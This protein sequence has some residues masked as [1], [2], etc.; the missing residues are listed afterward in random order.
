MVY[1]HATGKWLGNE[2]ESDLAG[3]DMSDDDMSSSTTGFV[4]SVR[5]S[6]RLSE[7]FNLDLALIQEFRDRENQHH[8]LDDW[9][10]NTSG[11]SESLVMKRKDLKKALTQRIVG[12]CEFAAVAR[13]RLLNN[14]R[15]YESDYDTDPFQSA[16]EHPALH[17]DG[18]ESDFEADFVDVPQ[19][20][21]HMRTAPSL[22]PRGLAPLPSPRAP[23]R[24]PGYSG[25]TIAHRRYEHQR[26][27]F[28]RKRHRAQMPLKSSQ[29]RVL[30]QSMLT[31]SS[32]NKSVKGAVRATSAASLSTALVR[33]D[34]EAGVEDQAVQKAVSSPA[35]QPTPVSR[36]TSVR[37]PRK[38]ASKRYPAGRASDVSMYKEITSSVGRL[39]DTSLSAS[40]SINKPRATP[41]HHRNSF[42]ATVLDTPY[43][44]P[45]RRTSSRSQTW[46]TRSSQ[47]QLLSQSVGARPK[48]MRRQPSDSLFVPNTSPAASLDVMWHS[49]TV[50]N[51]RLSRG[52]PRSSGKKQRPGADAL[53]VL[54]LRDELTVTSPPKTLISSSTI[55]NDQNNDNNNNNNNNEN[56]DDDDPDADVI[57]VG[58][59]QSEKNEN[60]SS[61]L[62]STTTTITN[63]ISRRCAIPFKIANDGTWSPSPR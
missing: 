10:K 13:K 7:E 59:D 51:S 36:Q 48:A 23:R 63:P 28:A 41:S 1:C 30:S 32:S 40:S 26:K 44:P 17:K 56:I 50:S 54:L 47:P 27:L 37:L 53:G 8:E 61:S 39:F 22:S 49:L 14:G 34:N 20:R 4:S 38:T 19:L 52:Q 16:S 11:K 43:Q 62:K 58:E 33:D 46:S 21:Q 5:M 24:S 57:V 15:D 45:L 25:S 55:V 35:T 2:E 3:F 6:P 60:N 29:Q 18:S 42:A 9:F 31:A 12:D